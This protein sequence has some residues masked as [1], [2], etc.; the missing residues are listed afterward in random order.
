[1]ET[2]NIKF[3]HQPIRELLQHAID[4]NPTAILI[5]YATPDGTWFNY[6]AWNGGNMNS[7]EMIG[8]AQLLLQNALQTHYELAKEQSENG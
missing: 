2:E 4:T 3:I 1:M 6:G 5:A 8:M 7:L